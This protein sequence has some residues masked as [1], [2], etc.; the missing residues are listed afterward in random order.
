MR[1]ARNRRFCT[2]VPLCLCLWFTVFLAGCSTDL[3]V[4]PE[5]GSSQSA[6]AVSIHSDGG[7]VVPE[8]ALKFIELPKIKGKDNLYG[9]ETYV[10]EDVTVKKGGKLHL[11]YAASGGENFHINSHL[12]VAPN[13]ISSDITVS[14]SL[15]HDMVLTEV[16]I[17][18]GAHG[19]DFSTPAEFK[20]EANNL[21]L[22]DIG[23]PED[24]GFYYYHEDTGLWE[25]LEA[26]L[27]VNLGNGHINA[28][29]FIDHF[30][31]YALAVSR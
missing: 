14:L 17:V 4:N 13:S 16:D 25:L 30:S 27:V 23:D 20:L 26:E 10:E 18:F 21:D 6:N 24:V 15:P 3:G 29:A 12:D 11:N 1:G 5:S 8:T 31:R 7:R 19:I 22:S 28:K 2:G 9:G